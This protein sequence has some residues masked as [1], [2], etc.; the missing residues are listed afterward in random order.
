[1]VAC[2]PALSGYTVSLRSFPTFTRGRT[3]LSSLRAQYAVDFY[4]GLAEISSG[5]MLPL[6]TANLLARVIVGSALEQMD[7]ERLIREV[8]VAVA[9]RVHSGRESV[10]DVAKELHEKLLLRNENTKQ[11]VVDDIYV[12]ASH[13]VSHPHQPD[14]IRQQEKSNEADHNVKV[15]KSV[16]SV[17]EAKQHLKSVS[18]TVA[19]FVKNI[20]SCFC[21]WFCRSRDRVSQGHIS[22]HAEEYLT[23]RTLLT[24]RRTVD[25]SHCRRDLHPLQL[26]VRA[27]LR[28]VV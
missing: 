6:T 12:R 23:L 25:R 5:L 11:V 22:N 26:H 4:R 13:Y 17:G 19:L 24:H 21:P 28:H 3:E 16:E 7:M 8:G 15:W 9:E 1:M 18:R 27:R 20:L 2:E 10:D 14:L